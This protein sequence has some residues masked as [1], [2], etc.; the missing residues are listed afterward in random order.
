MLQ[1]YDLC[2]KHYADESVR[3][4]PVD[5]EEKSDWSEG[6]S[7]GRRRPHCLTSRALDGDVRAPDI[8]SARES[9]PVNRPHYCIVHDFAPKSFEPLHHLFPSFLCKTN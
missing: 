2:S 8:Y 5:W 6:G 7:A 1:P 4:N 9:A 3:R